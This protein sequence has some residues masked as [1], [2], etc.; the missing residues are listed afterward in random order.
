MDFKTAVS[1][2]FRKY[3]TF[4]GRA[5]RPEYWWFILFLFL[6]QATTNI[7]DAT[8]FGTGGISGQPISVIVSL[9]LILPV[10]A[11]GARR[12]HDIGRSA[13]WL[14]LLLLPVIGSLVL[15]YW[16]LQPSQDGSNIY[17]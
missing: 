16:Y 17:D 15:L 2:C 5:T 4:D 10:I 13:W 14:L 1:T 3:A 9:A 7:L 8:L 6:V 12:L 11:V